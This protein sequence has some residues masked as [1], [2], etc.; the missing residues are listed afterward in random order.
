M[1]KQEVKADSNRCGTPFF[2]C[3]CKG[4]LVQ[5]RLTVNRSCRRYPSMHTAIKQRHYPHFHVHAGFPS[6]YLPIYTY[7]SG[8]SP[9]ANTAPNHLELPFSHVPA[10]VANL[11]VKYCLPSSG[12]GHHPAQ[13]QTGLTGNET[14]SN[15]INKKKSPNKKPN[16]I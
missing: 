9:L 7:A 13:H 2:Q 12:L 6:A 16:H 1:E 14:K 15:K 10:I 8:D 5:H 3:T 11:V 4:P